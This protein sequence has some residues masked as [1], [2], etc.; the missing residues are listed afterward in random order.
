MDYVRVQSHS[1][2]YAT[3]MSP[4]VA[5]Q[6]IRSLKIMMGYEGNFGGKESME[7][8]APKNSPRLLLPVNLL[9]SQIHTCVS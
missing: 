6:I 4:V 8:S 3:S 2:T 1:A 5:A 9:P 7:T